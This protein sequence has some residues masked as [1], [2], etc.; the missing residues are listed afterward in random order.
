MKKLSCHCI[1]SLFLLLTPIASFSIDSSIQRIRAY[2]QGAVFLDR[3]RNER[4][5]AYYLSQIESNPGHI[6][7]LEGYFEARTRACAFE[8]ALE[9]LL[10]LQGDR[11]NAAAE[12]AGRYLDGAVERGGRKFA[13]AAVA[14]REAGELS[15]AAGDTLS[16]LFCLQATAR[17]LLGVRNADGA[18][19]A[20]LEARTLFGHLPRDDR[21]L[22]EEAVILGEAHNI[23]D[24]IDEADS[25]YRHAL[26]IS[27]SKGYRRIRS[28]CLNGLGKLAEKRQMIAE[29]ADYYRAAFKDTRELGMTEK[30]AAILNNLGQTETRMGNFDVARGYLEEARDLAVSC[31]SD[32]MLG[33]IY[34]GLGAIAE[35]EGDSEEAL[36][37]FQE[38]FDRHGTG[39]NTW[40]ELGARLR[41]GYNYVNLGEY[42][43]AIEHYTYC[44]DV[45]ERM[46][47][48][49]GLSWTL[50]GLAL[51]NHRLGNLVR[52]EE[53]Y[54]RAYEVREKLGDRRG[55]AWSLNSKGMV[56]DMQGRYREA[57]AVETEAMKIY[58]ELGDE[59]GVGAV[60]FSMGSVYFYLGNYPRS[61]EHFEKALEIA[62]REKNSDLLF[63]AVSG[64][65]S[66]YSAAGRSDLAEGF[67]KR[68]LDLMRQ[69]QEPTRLAWALNNLASF[70]IQTGELEKAR[71]LLGEA[72]SLLQEGGQV[73]VKA[74]TL[75]LQGK[76]AESAQAAVP[77]TERALV[78]SE[79]YGLGELRWKCLSDLGLFYHT[80]G[81]FEKARKYQEEAILA[82]E[83]LKRSV[84]ADE[85]RRHMLRPAMHPYERMVTLIMEAGDG[86]VEAFEYTERSRAQILAALLQE[87]ASRTMGEGDE[88]LAEERDIISKRSFL[89][90]RLQDG[91]LTSE[92][93]R[94]LLGEIADL[95]KELLEL[96]MRSTGESADY[97]GAFGPVMEDIDLLLSSLN[98]SERL[99]SYFLGH[100]ASY[101]FSIREGE[102]SAYVLPSRDLIEEKV[103]HFISLLHQ[104]M[105]DP[106]GTGAGIPPEILTMAARELSQLLI[107]PVGSELED[108]ET[109]VIV[110]DGL[111]HRLPFAALRCEG[112][113]LIDL[114]DLYYAPSLRSLFYLRN[115]NEMQRG[116]P[117]AGEYDVIA[118]GAEGE[119]GAALDR[120][121]RVYPYTDIP[122]TPLPHAGEEAD[123]VA[124]LFERSLSLT[125]AEA[126]ERHVKESPLERAKLVHFAAHSYID[127]ADVHRSFIVMNPEAE[128][129]DNPADLIAGGIE[130][131]LLQWHEISDLHLNAALISLSA[132][133]SAG[134]VLAYG[135]GI[136]GLSQA[137]LYAG[138][139]CV[140]ATQM[141]VPDRYAG[142]FMVAFYRN[143][144]EGL[145]A[146]AS[147]R[148]VQLEAMQWESGKSGAALWSAFILLGDGNVSIR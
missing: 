35:A 52:A 83:S 19:Q 106:A 24:R 127:D 56:L 111:L 116:S 79:E 37:M 33:F 27:E 105:S 129:D 40:G 74:R 11:S 43:R 137:F 132:C 4:A 70:Y 125:G 107:G 138:G 130:D 61:I 119:H 128:H 14:F 114:H 121:R 15:L 47:S 91:S 146:A 124:G 9:Q 54:G 48:L 21:F 46:G 92:V 50:G 20:M 81:D 120:T 102:V 10:L 75:Y 117:D 142:R 85:L 108:G 67:Y 59:V 100:K 115:R 41:L 39:G 23:M 78:L 63:R 118:F 126:G 66:V 30:S 136:T 77:Y 38:S 140:L 112:G 109:L 55:M 16:A 134:G 45:Y 94:A 57:L 88:K 87:T 95:E 31:G 44:L 17:S 5:A 139:T 12:A 25:L 68:D 36:A 2:N 7:A 76:T 104:S 84:A 49:Y 6:E 96:H 72:D 32:W 62:E 145:T 141:D 69:Q 58:E 64:M 123:A 65:G 28:Y 22:S 147:L 60:N 131:G 148:K 97:A 99:I 51:A 34:Y 113:R 80:M 103:Q 13:E 110:P 90:S 133:R 73:H 101:L 42:S 143:I 29:A 82:V 8:N 1:A 86:A 122:I 93:R 3:G 98:E 18:I 89:Q 135:E 26:E 71:L 53:Y 144:K